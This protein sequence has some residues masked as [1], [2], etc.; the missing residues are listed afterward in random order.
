MGASLFTVTQQ[1]LQPPGGG[2]AAGGLH[3]VPVQPCRVVDT[4]SDA[5]QFGKPALA[6]G[7]VRSFAVPSSGCGI[8]SNAKAF[9]L[10]ATVVP[11]GSLGYITIFPTGLTQPLVS[12]LNS[13]DGRIKANA[14]IVPA[15]T[16]GAIS[17][18]ATNATELVLDI[19][20]YFV[21]PGLSFEALA[22]YPVAP[23]RVLDTRNPNG[24]LGGPILA[25][26]V[27]RSFPILSS[28]C[29]I[30][31]NARAY[32][33]NAT[34]VPSGPLGFLTLFP[35]GRAQ[36]LVSTLNAPT[37][38]IVANAAII[39][40]GDNGAI[41]AYVSG[42]SHLVI[43]INGYFAPPGG[44]TAQ[45]FFPVSP[46]RVADSRNPNGGLG[47]PVLAAN[48]TR[49]WPLSASSCGL[50]ATATAYSLNATV[51]PTTSLGYLTMWPAGQT[52]PLVSTLNAIGDPIVANAAI[53]PAG[54]ASGS[55]ATFVTDQTHLILDT[56]GYFA[57]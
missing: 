13:I 9:A 49:I 43:D 27:A 24:S 42:A 15:G 38:A 12:T 57:P 1:G 30:P 35:S 50:P 23:C 36:P 16:G 44:A 41:S 5:G 10:N 29:G 28:N 51:V 25:A 6:A 53:V 17:V 34:V 39:P 48:Q 46:C 21:E 4:R 37:G 47:G 22:F 14:A 8:P 33:M 3:F 7:S 40:A 2:G 54:G 18:F 55:I 56:N 32:S 45:R 31:A 52:Q 19:N 26:T 20:G 11:A